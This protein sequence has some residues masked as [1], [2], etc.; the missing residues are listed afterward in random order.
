MPFEHAALRRANLLVVQNAPE[1]DLAFLAGREDLPA[2][3]RKAHDCTG[4]LWPRSTA[5]SLPVT[6]SQ[7]RTVL[8]SP[9]LSRYWPSAEKATVR[10][11]AECPSND[12]CLAARAV[13]WPRAA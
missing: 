6:V 3:G 10:T 7:M 8:S 2:V 4:R 12:G 1:L 5:G 11:G 9:P 13:R